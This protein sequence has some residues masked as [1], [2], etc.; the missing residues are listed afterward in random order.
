MSQSPP[1]HL[2]LPRKNLRHLQNVPRSDSGNRNPRNALHID[3]IAVF[4]EKLV[5]L[6]KSRE[7]GMCEPSTPKLRNLSHPPYSHQYAH[8]RLKRALGW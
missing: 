7:S 6:P 1:N 4:A 8:D 5:R 2:Q 3:S